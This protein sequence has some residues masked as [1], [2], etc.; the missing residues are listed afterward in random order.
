MI[1]IN[2]NQMKSFVIFFAF[3]FFS[4]YLNAQEKIVN[5]VRVFQEGDR[6]YINY[7]L[8]KTS[9]I[10][11]LVLENGEEKLGFNP[12][13]DLGMVQ[14]GNSK[15]IVLLPQN[16]LMVCNDCV[17]RVVAD[18][19]DNNSLINVGGVFWM[20]SLPELT[21]WN[22]AKNVCPNGWRLASAQEWNALIAYLGGGQDAVRKIIVNVPQSLGSKISWWTDNSY[23]E[24]VGWSVNVDKTKFAYSFI[25]SPKGEE[26]LVRCVSNAKRK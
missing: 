4:F 14:A 8:Q 10:N 12:S 13:G 24:N 22:A 5:N 1:I 15:K 2:K 17:F 26:K 19:T 6:V 20:N 7:D 25:P 23:S 16:G 18:L 9:F 21:S 11:L 3:M